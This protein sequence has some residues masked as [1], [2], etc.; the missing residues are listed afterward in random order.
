[1]R[2][3]SP[4]STSGPGSAAGELLLGPAREVFGRSLTGR[5]YRPQAP[6]LAAELGNNAG[7]IGAADL[8]RT[9]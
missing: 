9:T 4:A 2:R 7:F 1:M 3:C 6:V 8:A 5:G